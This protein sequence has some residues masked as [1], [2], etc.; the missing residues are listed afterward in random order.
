RDDR[1]VSHGC[2]RVENLRDLA[3]L[4]MQQP[5]EAIDQAIET[6]DTTYS[7]LPQAVPVFVVY[8]T[9]FADADDRL[10]FRRDV[11]GR[12]AEIWQYLDPQQRPMAE[13]EAFGQRGG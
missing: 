2:I 1:R 7:T 10:Q 9:A 13:R 3:A 6:R 4:L 11:Y 8:E 12:D 5:A